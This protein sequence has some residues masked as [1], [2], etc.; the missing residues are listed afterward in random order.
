MSPSTTNPILLKAN[1]KK[2]QP[3]FAGRSQLDNWRITRSS[4]NEAGN[5]TIR[6]LLDNMK[7]ELLAAFPKSLI[8]LGINFNKQ[9]VD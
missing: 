4:T 9:R 3:S 5:Y 8:E 2:A 6:E 7:L 1:K